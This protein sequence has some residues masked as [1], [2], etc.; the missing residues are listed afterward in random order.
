MS[1]SR[2]ALENKTAAHPAGTRMTRSSAS[3]ARLTSPG[4]HQDAGPG[5][6]GKQRRKQA[7]SALAQDLSQMSVSGEH[8]SLW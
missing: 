6:Y 8:A 7:D 1:N 5:Q 2:P 3:Q 4:Q